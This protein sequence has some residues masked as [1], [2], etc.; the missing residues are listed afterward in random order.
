MQNVIKNGIKKAT[1]VILV[2]LGIAGLV[3]PALQGI[4]MILLGLTLIGNKKLLDRIKY[5]FKKIK[6]F[7][8]L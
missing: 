4:A 5:Y 3:L 7:F 8:K 2:V 6:S 1:G